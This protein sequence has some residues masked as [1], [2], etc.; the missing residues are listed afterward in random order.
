MITFNCADYVD[1]PQLLMS[2]LFGYEKGAFTGANSTKEGIIKQ[3]EH[4]ILFLDEVHRLPPQ[5]Q[6]MLFQVIDNQTYRRL[7]QVTPNT[8]GHI[9]FVMATT[10]DI[11]SAL[12]R[13]FTRRIPVSVNLPDLDDRFPTEKLDYIYLFFKAE[14]KQIGSS[15]LVDKSVIE[16]LLNYKTP[17]N[18]G[19]LKVDIKLT[20]AKAYMKE[21]GVLENKISITFND[22]PEKTIKSYF[23]EKNIK[24]Y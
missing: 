7:G 22:L 15:L 17:S 19:Q 12:L 24:K 4:G 13:T 8:I 10:E 2:L 9:L 3:A 23:K 20:C 6:E 5:A 16:A 11:S 1:N 21:N 18:L 14:A